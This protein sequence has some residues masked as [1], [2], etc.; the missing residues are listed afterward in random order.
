[1]NDLTPG[2]RL[3][4]RL[5]RHRHGLMGLGAVLS[6]AIAVHAGQRYLDERLE[7]ER[8]R[9]APEPVVMESVVVARHD[10]AKGDPISVDT[11]AVRAIP[12]AYA[13]SAAIRPARF[14]HYQ[15]G[16]LAV[17]LK[18]GEPLL[19]SAVVGV[20]Q[21][22]FS[23]RLRQGIR[24]LTI[25]VDEVNAISGLLQP[26]DRVDLF[27]SARPPK[28]GGAAAEAT[29]PLLQNVLVLATGRQVRPVTDQ[30]AGH[31][32]YGTITVELA[33]QQA[34]QVVVAQRAGRITAVLRHP[35]DRRLEAAGRM[36]LRQLFG[37]ADVARV[38]RG[39][40]L[41]IGGMGRQWVAGAGPSAAGSSAIASSAG[42]RATSAAP[43]GTAGEGDGGTPSAQ[44]LAP[45]PPASPAPPVSPAPP[46]SPAPPIPG[47]DRAALDP[48]MRGQR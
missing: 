14:D 19:D 32:G 18:A 47:R 45:A 40:Q 38:R 6:A 12:R 11:M 21:A 46:A 15:G 8:A 26:G 23:Q 10:L 1:M 27:F 37:Q 44:P 30:Q 43:G 9:L 22:V 28:G 3:R 7:A 35:D 24:A 33:P 34:Q 17:A 29:V 39:P 48:A 4:L 5:A 20:D 36:D 13:V 2:A 41:I 42:N 16:R 31:R 25:S